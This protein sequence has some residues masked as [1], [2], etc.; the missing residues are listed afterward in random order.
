MAPLPPQSALLPPPEGDRSLADDP[1]IRSHHPHLQPLRHPPHPAHVPRI[2]VPRE[3]DVA[4][5]R[6]PD[7]LVLR[8]EPDQRRER[9]ERF[10]LV[11]ERSGRD[12]GEDGREEERAWAVRTFA[13]DEHLR[14]ERDGVVHMSE[15]L[16]D[17]SLVD[18][19]AVRA[20]R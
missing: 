19:R 12:V 13:P 10:L 11:Q 4:V 15:H 1:R 18:K 5:V 7:H 9:T 8:L 2:K 14:A 6:Q 17:R 20:A 16:L 3:P